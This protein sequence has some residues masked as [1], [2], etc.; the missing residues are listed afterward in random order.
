MVAAHVDARLRFAVPQLF[1][2]ARVVIGVWALLSA[3]LHQLDLAAGLLIIGVVTD[4]L[5]GAAARMLGVESAFGW[6]FDLF[7]DYLYY[8][9]VPGVLSV[10]LSDAGSGPFAVLV[11]GLPFL[12][13]AIRYARNFN[14]GLNDPLAGV[15][16][17]GLGTNLYAFFIVALVFLKR[18]DAIQ[19]TTLQQLLLYAVPA[20]SV[21]M[22]APIRYPKLS[23][24]N[25]VLIPVLVGL[26][27]M[28]FVL[29]LPLAIVTLSLVAIYVVFSPLIV[30]Q[31]R[32][33]PSAVLN[34][35]D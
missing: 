14:L 28:P 8:I 34:R 24:H 12:T 29:T 7:S 26:N 27:A 13:G 11:L 17:P 21:L 16:T 20:L 25:F 33:S 5:D 4:A 30:D 15:S 32:I 18:E 22:I 19:S 3:V 23:R 1:T 31:R 35:P 2:S 10:I 9:V 6:L